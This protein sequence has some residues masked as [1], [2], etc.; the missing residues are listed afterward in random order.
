M[1]EQKR[2]ILRRL[3][4]T[5]ASKPTRDLQFVDG[6]NVV[7]GAS[8]AGKSFMVKALDYMCGAGSPLPA[9]RELQGYD[10]CW[11]ELDLPVSG[12]TT[13][14]RALTGGG[15]KLFSGTIGQA[16]T[17]IPFR[18]L[19]PAHSQPESLSSF[20]LAELGV[21]NKRIARNRDGETNA[22]TFRHF[23]TYVFTEETP[24]MAE[25]S[26]IR[27]SPQSGETFDKNVL[28]FILTGV[29]DSAVVA[30]KSRGDQRIA[31]AGKI[32]IVE[33][34]I[35]GAAEELKRLFPDREDLDI[36]DLE[37]QEAALSRTIDE[38]QATLAQR[39]S[40]L[41]RLR[42]ERR[43]A[44]DSREELRDR[45]AEIGV[46]LERFALLADVYD[47]DVGRLESLEEGAAALMAGAR[48][49][50]PLCG[51]EPEHQ[52]EVHGFE[53]VAR[54]QRAA[55]AEIAKIQKERADLGKA[56]ASLSAEQEGVAARIDR[57]S[58]LIFDFESQIET[59]RPLE[60]NNRGS[61][62]EL[63]Q[64]RQ[65]VRD[66]LALLRRIDNL[67]DRKIVL[68]AFRPSSRP[69]DS[70][71]VG[72]GGVIGH[73]F[74]STVQSILHAWRFPGDP[75]VSFDDRT[76]DILIDGKDRRGNGKGV[77]A[78]MNAAYKI[79]VLVY[80][81]AKELPH[82]G[83]VV[84]DSPLLSYRDPHTSKHGDLSA[85]E[86]AVTQTGL[87]EHFYRFLLDRG[88]GAQFVI[89]ENDAPPIDLGPT[90]KVTRF[91]GTQGEGG[92]RGLL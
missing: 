17:E 81:R 53:Q 11:L 36:T 91:V 31:N 33:E 1:N 28:K 7:W 86:R 42:F 68:E 82:P 21:A 12:H 47:S 16:Q 61:Y 20:L 25:W 89:V 5:G 15:I 77:R 3:A 65:R 44:L 52:S 75:V 66:G 48:R 88:A 39:Q 30:T 27:I 14:A 69:R 70:I 54:S 37:T 10:S 78:L 87:N 18:T 76:H 92:R 40:E 9:I 8:N 64:A 23:A 41:D 45:A 67:N 80:C 60:A 49:P 2:F 59:L 34:L 29:D 83:F 71:A 38:Q 51:A 56:T 50:C 72:V 35:A 6:L 57:L 79:G 62:E 4:F 26:P 55:R 46:T 13:L 74:A 90:A 73:E 32:E 43:S 58:A 85:D 22:F 24:M 63:D 84:L 19:A